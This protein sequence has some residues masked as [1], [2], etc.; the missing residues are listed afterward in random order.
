M[1]TKSS[2]RP[3]RTDIL[4]LASGLRCK[5]GDLAIVG[6]NRVFDENLGCVVE[7]IEAAGIFDD[8]GFCWRVRSVGRPM[9]VIDKD[10]RSKVWFNTEGVSPDRCLTP[11]KGIP[12]ED[13]EDEDVDCTLELPECRHV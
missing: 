11:I 1:T 2:A 12:A 7:I 4:S 13:A 8:F 3:E 10:D 6:G 5:P 9:K